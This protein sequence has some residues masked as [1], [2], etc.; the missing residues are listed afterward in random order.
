MIIAKREAQKT[1][2]SAATDASQPLCHPPRSSECSSSIG[3]GIALHASA[4]AAV[5][6]AVGEATVALAVADTHAPA[7]A[8]LQRGVA[9]E[10]TDEDMRRRRRH[11]DMRELAEDSRA[12]SRELATTALLQLGVVVGEMQGEDI[13]RRH[14]M[15]ELAEAFGLRL[16]GESSYN[17]SGRTGARGHYLSRSSDTLVLQSAGASR[18]YAARLMCRTTRL[19]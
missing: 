11:D 2:R 19:R 4:R 16:D 7:S 14:D 10:T 8:P 5:A 3:S 13:W 12:N 1:Q 9:G 15:R 18:Y 17:S 6:G